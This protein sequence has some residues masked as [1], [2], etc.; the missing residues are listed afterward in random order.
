[1]SCPVLASLAPGQLQ[2]VPSPF[3]NR[4]NLNL[5]YVFSLTSANLLRPYLLEAGLWGYSG[6]AGTT[7]GAKT[8]DGPATWHWG[9][10]SVTCELRGHILGHWLS[11]AAYLGEQTGHLEL[12]AKTTH[13]LNELARCQAANGGR[14]VGPFP[15][16]YLYR[17][18][19]GVGVWAPQYTLH[20]L[21]MGLYDAYAVGHHEVALEILTNFAA[22]FL[23]FTDGMDEDHLADLL[24]WETGGMLEVWANLYGVTGRPEHLELIRRYDRK[25]L[26][27]PLLEGR[28]VLTNKHAN[29]QIPEILGAARAYEVTGDERWRRITENFWDWAVTRRGTYCTG[30]GSNGEVWQPPFELS[31]RLQS[32]HEHCTVYNMMRLAQ[33]LYSW[34]GD[35][36]YADY[37]ERN[38]HN[39]ILA[40][41]HPETGMVSYFLPLG[42]GSQKKWGSRTDDFWCCHGTLMQAN[43]NY[44]QSVLFTEPDA[45][46]VS[47]FL[48]STTKWTN[49]F[50]T[51]VEFSLAQDTLQGLS[52]GQRFTPSGHYAIQYVHNPPSPVRRPDAYVYDLELKCA[53]PTAFTLKIRVPWWVQGTPKITINGEPV[54]AE[55]VTRPFILLRRVWS[56]DVIHLEF[57][58]ALTVEPLPDRPDQVAFMDGPLVLAGLVGEERTL[59]GDVCNPASLLIPDQERHHGWWNTGFYRTVGQDPGLRFVPI[60]EVRDEVY[61]VYFPV[62]GRK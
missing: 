39:A 36:D 12:R 14:W 6:S 47:Q 46:V 28:D 62:R 3:R 22:W 20:K 59:Y 30:G 23:E 49:L 18:K 8:T 21:V 58:K 1:M 17:I 2:L 34:T 38:F 61:G 11:A 32:P 44:D 40:Q 55:E 9:W 43:S 7:I 19:A 13:I 26:F 33:Y 57:R 31:A 15:D 10:E 35:A 50:G 37:W 60:S 48:P 53:E 27:E 56:Q 52:A 45:L 42:A 24:D 4:L 51:Q 16:K 41:Q 5:N 25:R 54:P 29:T